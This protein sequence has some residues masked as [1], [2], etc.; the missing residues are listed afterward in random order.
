MVQAREAAALAQW[1][2][3][4]ALYE[5][6]DQLPA[7]DAQAYVEGL[8][9]QDPELAD[10]LQRMLA[11]RRLAQRRGFLEALPSLPG[12]TTLPDA[13][14]VAGEGL[15]VGPW[16]L[17]R[18]LGSG[19]MAEV[20]LARRDD[21]AFTR[22]VAVKLLHR[23]AG[24]GQQPHLAQR[25]ARERDIL[26][27]LRHPHIAALHDAGV[28]ADGQ[29]WLALEF[30]EGAPITDACDSRR[31]PLRERVKLFRQVVQA[32]QHAHAHLVMH[33]DLKPANILVGADGQVRLLDFGIAKFAEVDGAGRVDSELTRAE[34]RP[35]TPRYAAPEQLLGLPLTIACD[36]YALGVVLYELLTGV[37]P[38]AVPGATAL[39]IESAILES[40]PRPPSRAGGGEVAAA[41]RA[42]MPAVLARQLAGDLDAVVLHALGRQPAERYASA[43]ALLADL[44][45]WLAGEPV[46]AR[47][48]GAWYRARRF[49]GRH[50][51]GVALGALA[52][53]GL[54][55]T[56][57]VAVWAALQAREESA[58]A[59]AARDFMLEI[60]R[61]ADPE[62]SRGAT[63][64]AAEVL[65]AGRRDI[66]T[67]LQGQP[68][69]QAELLG[70]IAAIQVDL[71][72]YGAAQDSLAEARRLQQQTGD[73]TGAVDSSLRLAE[74]AWAAGQLDE[75][76]AAVRAARELGAGA[77]GDAALLSRVRVMEGEIDFA[78]G[79]HASAREAF[80]EA[81]ALAQ[82]HPNLE[83]EALRGLAEVAT[84][85]HRDAE[86]A[87]LYERLRELAATVPGLPARSRALVA[88]DHANALLSQ[89]WVAQAQGLAD[90]AHADCRREIGE[91]AELCM[92]LLLHR[93]QARL[94]TERLADVAPLVATWQRAPGSDAPMNRTRA[95]LQLARIEAARGD[96]AAL[97]P[98][99][100]HLQAVADGSAETRQTG[101][102]R[103]LAELVLADV[104]LRS[105]EPA[106]AESRARAALQASPPPSGEAAGWARTLLGAALLQQGKAAAALPLFEDAAAQYARALP[107]GHPRVQ[108]FE[109]NRAAALAALGRR[110][111]AQAIVDAALPVLAQAMGVDSPVLARARSLSRRLSE[112]RPAQAADGSG[113]PFFT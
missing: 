57:A 31:A 46:R 42:T 17:L 82:G 92:R 86:V 11:A 101:P 7:A 112:A 85:L 40:A 109:L 93:L 110:A 27:A 99:V 3:L 60:F 12:A 90:T 105:G 55:A 34:G 102:W 91:F 33:R 74:A 70:G 30:V 94:R 47:K 20:W 14:V 66:G 65:Q 64:S 75:A 106:V 96:R 103:T 81:L 104:A 25:F 69:L 56:S 24:I 38:Y 4:S 100:T 113:W 67:R 36:V 83:F 49:A 88:K 54:L 41:A 8:R 78:K 21:G 89:G 53:S 10:A 71:A 50:R 35:M 73:R 77:G 13:V 97:A 87:P 111:E 2:A 22:E 16:R 23:Q 108:L 72:Q 80:A 37:H 61:S 5:E 28:S 18:R 19:G 58:R 84:P 63:I 32:V 76:S 52:A 95:A 45:R 44:D 79:R 26:A 59:M 98:W 29:P 1:Q 15:R 107:A 43:D 6:V 68:R 48:P 62:R 51:V 39:R 9:S